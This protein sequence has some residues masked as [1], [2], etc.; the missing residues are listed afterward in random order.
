M[1]E[2]ARRT[3][4]IDG[5]DSAR[6]PAHDAWLLTCESHALQIMALDLFEDRQTVKDQVLCA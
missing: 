2:P 5:S 3:L 6:S 4:A 1:A